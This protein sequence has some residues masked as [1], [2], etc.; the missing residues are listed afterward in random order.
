MG[1]SG[2]MRWAGLAA[3]AGAMLAMTGVAM[4]Q[5]SPP[6][7]TALGDQPIAAADLHEAYYHW[8]GETVTIVAYPSLFWTPEPFQE[9]IEVGAEPIERGPVLAEC[10][11]LETPQGNMHSDVTLVLRGTF[12][13]RS[14]AVPADQPPRM[15][16]RDCELLSSGDALPPG[17]DPWTTGDTPVAIDALHDAVFGWEGQKVR[18]VGYYRSTTVS[19]VSGGELTSQDLAASEGGPTIVEC[20]QS[21]NVEAPADVIAERNNVVVEGTFS[22]GYGSTVILEDCGFFDR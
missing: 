9:R 1:F 20:R 21:G 2:S 5:K 6:Q 16:L 3:S 15:E 7:V 17:S 19:T 8:T 12:D 22:K 18:V 11:F 4:A 14:F 13:A 10:T